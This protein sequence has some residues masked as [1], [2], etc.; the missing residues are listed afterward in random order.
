MAYNI[1][2]NP[3]LEKLTSESESKNSN[4]NQDEYPFRSWI[5]KRKAAMETEKAKE[6]RVSN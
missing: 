6:K 3:A 1:Y 4:A 5:L 2:C